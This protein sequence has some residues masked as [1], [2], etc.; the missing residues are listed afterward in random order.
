MNNRI[1]P[2][3]IYWPRKVDIGNGTKD[4]L[5]EVLNFRIKTLSIAEYQSV[6]RE[7]PNAFDLED[8]IISSYTVE[9]PEYFGQSLWS[10]DEVPAGIQSTLYKK[11]LSLSGLQDDPDPIIVAEVNEYIDS[12]RFKS[13]LLIMT[14]F[15]S[16]T[17]ENLESLHIANY[18]KLLRLAQVKLSRLGFPVDAILNPEEYDAAVAAKNNE[19]ASGNRSVDTYETGKKGRYVELENISY[20]SR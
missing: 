2:L 6:R 16:Y 4:V 7:N 10:W 13:D 14:A 11:I 5:H 1:Y 3:T 20:G 18:L 12:D 19:K 9:Y 17:L 15:D 8:S